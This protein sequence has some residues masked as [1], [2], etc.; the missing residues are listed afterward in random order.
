MKQLLLIILFVIPFSIIAQED[1]EIKMLTLEELLNVKVEVASKFSSTLD[2]SPGIVTVIDRKMIETTCTQTL[3]DIIRMV[4]GMDFSKGSLGWGEPLDEYYGRGVLNSFS[5]TVLLLLNGQ[6]R[7][8]DFTYASPFMSTRINVDMIE[9]I[10]IIRG[11]GS[12]LYGGN[13]FAAVINI[14]TR[15]KSAKQETIFEISGGQNPHG[16]AYVLTKH[17]LFNTDWQIGLQGKYFFD[18]GRTYSSTEVDNVYNSELPDK[19]KIT[20]GIDPSYDLSLN[21]SAPENKFNAQ[22][23]HT[24]HNPH[25]FLTGFFP[26]PNEYKYQTK[27][28]FFNADF[29]PIKNFTFSAYHSI[30]TWDSRLSLY[31][32]PESTV[33]TRYSDLD[34]YGTSQKN[35]NSVLSAAYNTDIN[36]HNIYIGAVYTRDKQTEPTTTYHSEIAQAY[37]YIATGIPKKEV[38]FTEQDT[39]WVS[40]LSQAR[41]QISFFVQDNWKISDKLTATIGL[42]YDYFDDLKENS[43]LNPRLGIIWKASD[44]DKFKILYGHA[45]RPPSPSETSIILY[46]IKG[47]SDLEAERIM[48][49]E[50]AYIHYFSF[51]RF[52]INGF[53]SKVKDPISYVSQ[54]IQYAD[55]Y[56]DSYK[57]MG[58]SDIIGGEIELHGKFWW[59]NY[60]FVD[61]QTDTGEGKNTTQFVATHQINAGISYNIVDNLTVN[62]QIFYK[63]PRP[64]LT[65]VDKESK[66]YFVDDFSVNY[67]IKFL[68][69]NLG[70]RN[71]FDNVWKMPMSDGAYMYPYRGRELFGKLIIKI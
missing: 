57:N 61:S 46:P 19:D 39:G 69:I 65:D 25:P 40:Y 49:G 16:S 54:G 21:I 63:S 37:G 32:E 47:N 48:T 68:N 20:D 22:I 45:F 24:D 36:S 67:K 55:D 30:M 53:Y 66:A 6:N 17:K 5:Q 11:P 10:E 23:W 26:Q 15:D 71:I 7:F 9:R 60:S 29:S 14:I 42:R 52:Q 56:W 70:C 41:N 62:N 38:I 18:N 28:T 4:P 3:A 58:G 2:D 12:A 50:I 31:W 27:Q 1:E 43:I 59:V 64:L 44:K 33:G 13:A 51:A 34:L 8:N 35:L